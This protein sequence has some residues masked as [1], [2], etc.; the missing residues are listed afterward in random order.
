MVDD[1]RLRPQP[2]DGEPQVSSLEALRTA[3]ACMSPERRRGLVRVLLLMSVAAA[4]DGVGIGAVLPLAAALG[5]DAVVVGS[6]TPAWMKLVSELR[7]ADAV[8]VT[9]AA[10]FL[11]FAGKNA[12]QYLVLR[13][14]LR[15][16][17]GEFGS[18]S[19]RLYRSYMDAP[20][21]TQ[22]QQNL[23]GVTRNIVHD[24]NEVY[25]TLLSSALLLTTHVLGALAVLTVLLLVD[26]R[27]VVA[28]VG[29]TSVTGFAVLLSVRRGTDSSAVARRHAR[30]ETLRWVQE[31]FSAFKEIR[32]FGC[33]S[34]FADGYARALDR[35]V[36]ADVFH[37]LTRRVPRL[38]TETVGV[39][40]VAVAIAI[41]ARGDSLDARWLPVLAAFGVALARL[42]PAVQGIV[43][44]LLRLRQAAPAISSVR[45]LKP[46]RART[47]PPPL[48]REL[49][50]EGVTVRYPGANRN[51][52][53][54]VSLTLRMGETLALVGPTGAGKTTVGDVI[55]GLVSPSA[56]TVR[57]DGTAA[58]N[59]RGV[60]P[61]RMGYVPQ[62]PH[63][64]DD[65]VRRNV[66][67]GQEDDEIDDDALW[68]A[69]EQAGLAQ[70][71]RALP[72]GLQNQVGER[73]AR[74]SG[75]Q[76]QRLAIARALYRRPSVIVLDE[77]TSS[78]D[79]TTERAVHDALFSLEDRPALLVIA[80]RNSTARRCERV[81]VLR[82]G[83][84]AAVGTWEELADD[85]ALKGLLS[86]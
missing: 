54:D 60:S 79:A 43:G 19:T 64:L 84:L 70:T 3:V 32:V 50:L 44:E 23:P 4:L 9:A 11:L 85:D 66:A 69:L 56:G 2:D 81:A 58:T 74:I 34:Y 72:H 67:L 59:D 31:G 26:A 28:A 61:E 5:A 77:A 6:D 53:E 65:T 83:H 25:G 37:L 41:L 42:V 36:E 39:G 78:L 20:W 21:E 29:L 12:F 27:V 18:V 80:H 38:L 8:P 13:A 55:L 57:F 22:S 46:V 15:L 10:V 68:W 82:D 35:L 17:L 73:G 76:Q 16:A 30:K 86:S 45:D 75:G 62:R 63:M 7:A 1:Q 40:A 52:L 51:A 33:E 14:Q 71:V 24:V 49:S 48:Q 47:R